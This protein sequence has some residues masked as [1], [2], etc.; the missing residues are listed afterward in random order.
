[1]NRIDQLLNCMDMPELPVEALAPE[2]ISGI[3]KKT[4]QF[5]HAQTKTRAPHRTLR[6]VLAAAAAAAVLCTS[7][8]AAQKLGLIDFT[9]IF[10][11]KSAELA[12]HT[13]TFEEYP[14]AKEDALPTYTAKAG[15]YHITPVSAYATKTILS[16]TVDCSRTEESV[17]AFQESGL[18]LGLSGFDAVQ[19][20][21]LDTEDPRYVLCA[22]LDEPLEAGKEAAVY[23]TDGETQTELLHVPVEAAEAGAETEF[24]SG[25]LKRAVFTQVSLYVEGNCGA[26]SEPVKSGTLDFSG[27]SIE[28]YDSVQVQPEWDLQGYL[29]RCETEADGTFRLEWA[30]TKQTPFSFRTLH[31]DGLDY[32]LPE[33]TPEETAVEQTAPRFGTTAQT[34]DYAFTLESVTADENAA[35][36]IV[37]VEPRTEYGAAHMGETMPQWSAA[38]SNR[39]AGTGLFGSTLVEN[40]EDAC[41]YL[42]WC[43]GNGTP[44]AEGDVLDAQILDILEPGDT[45]TH[46]YDLFCETLGPVLQG[47]VRAEGGAYRVILT[48]LTFRLED[49][50][51]GNV[52]GREFPEVSLSFRDG[53]VQALCRNENFGTF[54]LARLHM[55]G[56]EEKLVWEG[57]FTAAIDPAEVTGVTIDGV[58]YSVE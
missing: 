4:L 48:P 24:S 44:F 31:Y 6:C 47:S 11:A 19:M 52:D 36:A 16:V 3:T 56:T 51:G 58:F 38:L 41:R 30:F 25:T 20:L 35:C 54:G 9:A 17:P 23:L 27:F 53:T 34:Q 29:V 33:L 28:L 10:G 50:R 49:M 43:T 5:V 14:A 8:F 15:D 45:S 32:E 12:E 40:G 37:R 57:L 55:S 7:A 2:R 26:G 13:K 46:S 39:T 42:L 21:C 1:M 22:P 18:K